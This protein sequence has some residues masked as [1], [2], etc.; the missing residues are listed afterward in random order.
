MKDN[1]TLID[2]LY[3]HSGGGKTIIDE[4]ISKIASDKSKKDF[5]FLI[6]SRLKRSYNSYI[7]KKINFIFL[8]SNLFSRTLFYIK[9]GNLFSRY[10]CLGNVPPPILT[11]K[12]TIVYFQ[13]ELFINSS[14]FSLSIAKRLVFLLKS[15]YIYFLIS[16]NIEFIT[17]TELMKSKLKNKFNLDDKKVKVFPIFKEFK[18]QINKIKRKNSFLYVADI[19]IHKNHGRLLEGFI[20]AANSTNQNI[21]L[22]LTLDKADF[23]NSIYNSKKTPK[24]LIVANHGIVSKDYLLKL[25][26]QNRF[27]IYPSLI[28]SFGLPLI[29]A[30]SS[31][32]MLVT[33]NLEYVFQ[34]VTPTL[35]F[36][37]RSIESI[38]STIIES[39]KSKKLKK[40]KILVSNKIDKFVKHIKKNV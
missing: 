35:V 23:K 30:V 32:C 6:D 12:R 10:I 3:I 13:N 18:S 8:D 22:S 37:P 17:Q 9:K 14:T 20:M 2:C 26:N 25:Y 27:L 1:L 21:Y 15:T 36:N 24:N 19:S 16:Q 5:F 40:S 31:Q 39:I 33:S 4:V 11:K 29:E 28:E 38:S 7:L 34:V